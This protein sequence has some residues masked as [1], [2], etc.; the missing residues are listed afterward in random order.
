MLTKN[1]FS[2]FF[3]KIRP[4]KKDFLYKGISSALL[5]ML[6]SGCDL[7]S[8]RILY[9]P[10]IR[11][12][13]SD[14]S[15][16]FGSKQPPY[17]EL[18]VQGFSQQL[19]DRLSQL[20]P[21][22]AK[23]PQIVKTFKEKIA[24]DFIVDS[25]IEIWF[26]S[27]KLTVSQ[28]ELESE[29]QAVVRNY[30]TDRAFREELAILQMSHQQWIRSVELGIKRKYLFK[31]LQSKIDQITDDELKSYYENNKSKYQQRES[32]LAKS[33]LVLDEAQ[34]EVII[35]L[36]KKRTFD[37]LITEFSKESPLPKDGLYG[38]VERDVSPDLDQLFINNKAE[39][40]GPMQF[41]EGFRLFKIVQKRAARQRTFEE[42]LEPVRNEV[43]ALREAAQFSAWLDE[44]IKKH[45]IFK[46][47]YAID[48]LRVET[49]D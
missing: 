16:G 11:I 13:S 8:F 34:A 43:L 31:S 18:S 44:Q 3:L 7:F 37:E 33:I 30:P 15:S 2:S 45:K 12:E 4:S 5:I 9:K 26:E 6:L 19:A 17:R 28:S 27:S 29:A 38:W 32:L 39:I 40:I 35:K 24:A 22:S 10:L 25:L 48:S 1:C 23:D 47:T 46:N 20:D 49:R 21:L 14:G 41:N 42:V 36:S